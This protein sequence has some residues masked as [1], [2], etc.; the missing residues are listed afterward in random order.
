[1]GIKAKGNRL[2]LSG[3]LD[4]EATQKLKDVFL[5]MINQQTKNIMVETA[6]VESMDVSILQVILSGR[7]TLEEKGLKIALVGPSEVV[8]QLLTETGVTFAEAD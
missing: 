4:I 1:M 5:G 8:V 2:I 6:K 7:K 3:T